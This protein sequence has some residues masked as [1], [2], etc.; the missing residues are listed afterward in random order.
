MID[1]VVDRNDFN[2][3]TKLKAIYVIFNYTPGTC[4]LRIK[5]ERGQPNILR[6][7]IRF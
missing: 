6:A 4:K 1:T 3:L 2:N 7:S 5:C